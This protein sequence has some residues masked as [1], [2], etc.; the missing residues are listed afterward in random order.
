MWVLVEVCAI[1]GGAW[2]RCAARTDIP[3][4]TAGQTGQHCGTAALHHR[5]RNHLRAAHLQVDW[6]VEV[7]PKIVH[8]RVRISTYSCVIPLNAEWT[9]RPHHPPTSASP[10][11]EIPVRRS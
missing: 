9:F 8:E 6:L 10:H 11:D 1:D 2:I 3:T 7:W 5:G 4:G